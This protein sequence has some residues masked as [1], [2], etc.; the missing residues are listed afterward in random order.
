MFCSQCGTKVEAEARFCTQCGK[1]I[2]SSASATPVVEATTKSVAA[3]TCPNCSASV[4]LD[5]ASCPKCQAVFGEGSAWRVLPTGGAVAPKETPARPPA[6]GR[7]A[8]YAPFILGI[9]V[10]GVLLLLFW[11]GNMN[12]LQSPGDSMALIL[13]GV[14]GGTAIVIAMEASRAGMISN[15]KEGTYS[16]TTWF[17]LLVLLWIVCY[18]VYLYKRKRFGLTNHAL[19]GVIVAIGFTGTMV[20]ME[21]ALEGKKKEIRDK[22]SGLEKDLGELSAAFK[23]PALPRPPVAVVRATSPTGFT[24]EQMTALRGVHAGLALEQPHV[25]VVF[26][27]IMREHFDTLQQNLSV[28]GDI[29]EVDGFLFAFGCAAHM[30]GD[31]D[32]A[33]MID[34][35][36]GK[37]YVVVSTSEEVRWWGEQKLDQFKGPMRQWLSDTGN[38]ERKS[39]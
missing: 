13:V 39:K 19:L 38:L 30:C 37:P 7:S 10:V 33:F 27:E 15:R 9:P 23:A 32:A 17:F 21:L 14:I 29:I 12:L 18:P 36:S 20:A 31:H 24:A 1:Q 4:A 16:P 26:K 35:S 6:A 5:A 34:K 28:S 2:T 11:V 3:G 25:A 22:L 8:D